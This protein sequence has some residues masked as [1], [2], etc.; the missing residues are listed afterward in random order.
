MLPRS[1]PSRALLLRPRR[2]RRQNQAAPDK[3]VAEVKTE[4]VARRQHEE[5]VAELEQELKDAIGKCEALEEKTRAQAAE[6]AKALQEAKEA[7]TES[8]GAREEIRQAEQ[9]AAGKPFLCIVYLW[10]KIC[11]AHSTVEFSR[12]LCG[13]SEECRRRRT[14]LPSPGGELNREVVLVTVPGA[15]ASNASEQPHE[16]AVEAA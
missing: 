10:S 13:S 12:R 3:A 9:M 7:R 14:V 15:G 6:L 11:L 4:Q 2:R 1:S 8:R 16:A 5:R